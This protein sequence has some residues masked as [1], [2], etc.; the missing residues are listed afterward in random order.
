MYLSALIIFFMNFFF[1]FLTWCLCNCILFYTVVKDSGVKSFKTKMFQSPW[2]RFFQD[3]ELRLTI[4]QDVIRTYAFI[5]L[6]TS[7]SVLF[8]PCVSSLVILFLFDLNLF[9]IFS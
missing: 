1:Y 9:I 2:N 3:N 4:K 7:V 6:F 5:L 8:C